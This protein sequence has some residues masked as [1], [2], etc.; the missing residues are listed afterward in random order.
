MRR[1]GVRPRFAAVVPDGGH[2]AVN[3]PTLT[4]GPPDPRAPTGRT[5]RF[6]PPI[7]PL[8]VLGG[9]PRAR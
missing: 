4:M 9:R 5:A 1:P 6:E 8:R 7:S 3:R 2:P